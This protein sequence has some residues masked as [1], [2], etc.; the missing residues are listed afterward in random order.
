MKINERDLILAQKKEFGAYKGLL[1][2]GTDEGGVLDHFQTSSKAINPQNDPLVFIDMSG[3]QIQENPDFIYSQAVS[4][5]F[6][7]DKKV[8]RIEDPQT[9]FDKI[10]EDLLQQAGLSAFFLIRAGNL[11]TGTKLRTL[12]EKHPEIATLVC[13][14]DD[15]KSLHTAITQ[16]M[17]KNAYTCSPDAMQYLIQ[18]LG[19]NRAQT[20]QELEKL[21]IYLGDE[22]HVSYETVK[23]VLTD[24]SAMDFSDLSYALTNGQP[25]KLPFFFHRFFQEGTS[26]ITL[27]RS[28]L[29]YFQDLY[30]MKQYMHTGMTAKASAKKVI[31]YLF[32]KIEGVYLYAIQKWRESDF[33]YALQLLMETEKLCKTDSNIAETTTRMAFLKLALRGVKRN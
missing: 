18:H 7:S 13:Y 32:F 19:E 10:L 33:I 26:S 28:T 20:R 15:A 25:E 2:F 11:K 12:C 27:I 16:F 22:R 1:I 21:S 9:G 5:S 29:R 8:I 14:P 23:K 30:W 6:F 17:H 24:G 31:P 4:D 3:K